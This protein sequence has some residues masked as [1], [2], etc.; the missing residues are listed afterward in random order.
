MKV[1]DRLH[2]LVEDED[3][4]VD[5]NNFKSNLLNSINPMIKHH[6]RKGGITVTINT[7]VGYDSEYVLLNESKNLNRM[8]SAQLVLNNRMIIK[9]PVY[10]QFKMGSLHS[11]TSEIYTYD[12]KGIDLK[13]EENINYSLELIKEY[14]QSS[15]KELLSDIEAKLASLDVNQVSIIHQES[16]HSKHYVFPLSRNV[17]LFKLLSE[18]GYSFKELVNDVESMVNPLIKEELHNIKEL[19]YSDWVDVKYNQFLDRLLSQKMCRV[20]RCYKGDKISIT[21]TKKVYLCCHLTTADLSVLKDFDVFKEDL[22]IVNK[23]YVTRG[24]GL[25]VGNTLVNIR[26]TSLLAPAG[27]KSLSSI[28]DLYEEEYKK[29]SI[30]KEYKSDMEKLLKDHPLLFEEYAIRDSEI[31]LKHANEMEIF[32]H[33]VKKLGVPLTLSSIGKEYV[34]NH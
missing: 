18:E 15:Y 29:I 16:R 4:F 20:F 26:D 27:K 23:V 11:L 21:F 12:S 10:E 19:L 8:L 9:M 7:V 32:N 28:G 5:L 25:T 1:L 24:K 13:L 30:P 34:L 2:E 22:D 31:T 33:K 6:F 17:R 14:E 3:L